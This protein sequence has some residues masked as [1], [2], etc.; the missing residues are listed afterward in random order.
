MQRYDTAR[1]VSILGIFGNLFL[2]II[3]FL[4]AFVSHSQAMIADAFN[5]AGD[6]FSSILT[7]VGNKI[8][9]RPR[10]LKHNL[11]YGK[12]EY[13]YSI[14]IAISMIYISLNLF[15][16]SFKS[17]FVPSNYHFSIYL[18][19]VCIITIITKLALYIYTKKVGKKYNNLL[20]LSNAIDHKNDCLLTCGNLIASICAMK[21]IFWVDSLIGVII[22]SWILYSA[23]KI[24]IEAY[25]I[26]MDRSI[27]EE[28]KEK[29]IE[30][31]KKH[32][33][34]LK[35]NHVNSTPI[36]YQFQVNLTIFVDGNMSTFESHEIAN[37]I[38]KELTKLDII[39][40]AV[41]HVNPMEINQ[42]QKRK[43]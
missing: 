24:F 12:A 17:F 25:K 30:I 27:D 39:S 34:V 32:P 20:I 10:D 2:L 40:L 36:G 26:L 41:I 3:K 31:V 21:N 14:F 18:I 42:K 8:A 43:L 38:E 5:S 7:F 28:T 4:V 16:V 19:I 11:G 9:S 22:S 15:Y 29:V 1:K 35:V 13:I 23:L 6:I 37:N 33:E